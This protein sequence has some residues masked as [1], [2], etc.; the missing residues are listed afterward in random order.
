MTKSWRNRQC[1]QNGRSMT[2]EHNCIMTHEHFWQ[3]MTAEKEAVVT[4]AQKMSAWFSGESSMQCTLQGS[5]P[6]PPLVTAAWQLSSADIRNGRWISKKPSPWIRSG[7]TWSCKVPKARNWA[8]GSLRSSGGGHSNQGQACEMY[9]S[10]VIPF[11]SSWNCSVHI[12]PGRP[13]R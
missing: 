3:P 9:G 10:K 7:S 4:F 2:H 12:L 13:S 1:L 11:R 5:L 6:F 8:V